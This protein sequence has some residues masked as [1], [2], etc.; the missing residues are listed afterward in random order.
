MNKRLKFILNFAKPHKLKFIILFL[1]IVIAT[2]S[3]ALYPY[4][5]GKLVDEVFYQKNLKQLIQIVISYIFIFV[6]NQ[7]IHF[8]QNM[9]WSSLMTDFLYDIRTSIFQK[10][11]S[12]KGK[13]LS[14]QYSGDIIS[15]MGGD[16]EQFMNFINWNVFYTISSILKLFISLAFILYFNIVLGIFTILCTPIIVYTSRYFSK[17]NKKNYFEIVTKQGVLFAWLFE[18]IKGIQNIRL[19]NATKKVLS[20]YSSKAIK[21]VRFQIEAGKIELLS[22]RVNSG[23]SLLSQLILYVISAIFI[24]NGNLTVGQFTACIS[25][26]GSCISAFKAI[27]NRLLSITSNL[28]SVDRVIDIFEK[29]SETL[30]EDAPYNNIEKGNI[31]LKNVWFQYTEETP[32]LKG[33]NLEIHHGEKI[34]LVGHSGAGKS[35]IVSLIEKFYEPDSGSITI[36]GININNYNLHSLREQIGTVH[37]ENI[38]FEDTVRFNI[39]F[40]NNKDNDGNIYKALKEANLYDFIRSLPDGLDTKLGTSG[41]IFSGGQKQ[42]LIIARIFY[43]NPKILIFDEA[44]SALDNEAEE[45]IKSSWNDICNNRTI[46]IIAHRLSTI[47][48]SDKV[49][50]VN[51]GKIVGYDS[52]LNLLKSC[53]L[54]LELFKEQYNN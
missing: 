6:F 37:Q 19:L 42:R 33:I 25:Y 48:S 28:I 29:E 17:K 38:L 27:N 16:T 44:T 23:I 39:V 21:I 41:I 12:Y 45:V 43:K 2:F 18:I 35:T 10:V 54:Y 24:I 14:S 36:D 22:E 49:A 11:L 32:V 40:N 46:I 30:N 5:F 13:Y 4:I 3:G 1:F 53:S 26:F 50:V 47:L 9:T 34:S 51:D 15:R 52:H 7:A 20:D 31:E 8:F